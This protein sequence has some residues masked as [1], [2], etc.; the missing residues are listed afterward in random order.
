MKNLTTQTLLAT[1]GSLAIL[2]SPAFAQTNDENYEIIVT[3]V[4][5]ATTVFDSTASVSSISD[6]AIENLAPRSINEL[7]RSL[8]GIKA[9][10]TGGDANANI[11]VRGL[12]IAS[13]GSRYLSM[14][15]NGFP[16]LLIGDAAFATADS[17]VRVDS[18][19]GSVQAIRGGS[20]ATQAPNAAGGI[21]NLIS[22]KPTE[23]GGSVAATLGL[24]Y[25]SQRLDAE[26]GGVFGD[27]GYYHIGGFY[28][29]GEGVRE[30]RGSQEEGFQ[31]KASVGNDFDRGSIAI[32]F[33]HLDDTVPTYLPLPARVQSDGS[34]GTIGLDLGDGTNS[35]GL[36]DF[37]ARA[38]GNFASYKEGFQAEMTT[39][40]VVGD[41]EINDNFTVAAKA[42]TADISGNFYSP[43]PASIAAGSNPGEEDISFALFNTS[44]PD[45]GNTFGDVNL[46]GDF[47]M[48]SFKAGIEI[49]DQKSRQEW[50]FN[51][52]RATLV[53]GRLVTNG[54]PGSFTN[55]AGGAFINGYSSNAA[56]GGCCSRLYN[57]DIEQFAPYISGTLELDRLTLDASFRRNENEISGTFSEASLTGPQDADG[58]GTVGT[59]ETNVGTIDTAP[60]TINL[61][62]RQ[63][64]TGLQ[65][66][67]YDADY[68]AF[69]IGANYEVDDRLAVFANYSEGASVT[70]PDRSTGL[71]LAPAGATS[72]TGNVL[73]GS[74]DQF[75]NFVDAFEIGA[76]FRVTNGDFSVVYFN[77]DVR[78][79]GQL[80]AS[81]LRVLQNSFDTT[82]I[83]VEGDFY[84]DNGFGVRGNATFTD[85]EISGPSTDANL[86]NTPRR[87]APSI[88]NVNPYFEGEGYDVGFN[89]FHTAKAPVG[90][91]NQFDLPEYTTVGA[92]FNYDV[93]ENLGLSFNAN[94]LFDEV[95]F[96][97]GEESS[98]VAGDFVR[99]RPINGRTVS[100]T[101]RYD[102]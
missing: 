52:A 12:P 58:N 74:N 20:S 71:L 41:F 49:A 81:T 102:F 29:T 46:Q 84:F 90:N 59:N 34:I 14:Q 89:I 17:F 24:D 36:T 78:E 51:E 5:K 70:S 53:G 91:D 86:G 21:V 67:S 15:E 38:N 22:K 95:G 60:G 25:D 50:N 11:K 63:A 100:A 33:K 61:T 57:F 56:F 98:P 30:V 85:S 47:G 9:E 66:A 44:I 32:H 2:T 13:G 40:A 65:R 68:D 93:R 92:Y 94:N 4:A 7:F 80:E 88:F 43:F 28:R 48:L 82:G 54:A 31:I 42:R 16:T 19:I 96:S 23:N 35:L 18:T 39:L 72:T 55:P 3:G 101:L 73:T 37:A 79:G 76:K 87:Q 6:E 8:P 69:S 83:E 27:G 97:E 77:A 99:F 75:L 26:Y 10:D 62:T 45:M 64:A 1:A